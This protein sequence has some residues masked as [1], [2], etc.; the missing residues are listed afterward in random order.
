MNVILA[1]GF[2]AIEVQMNASAAVIENLDAVLPVEPAAKGDGLV[3][4]S[5][6]CGSNNYER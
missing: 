6:C 4:S 3:F 1:T 2:N 5:D